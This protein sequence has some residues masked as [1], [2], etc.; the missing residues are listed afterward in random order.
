MRCFV[1]GATGVL[2]RPLVPRLVSAG[3]EVVAVTRS[4][5]KADGLRAAGA[6]PV[7]VDLFEPNAVLAATEGCDAIIHVATNVPPLSKAA[8]RSAWALHNRLRTEA[9]TNL[10]AAAGLN[11]VRCF[12]K[13]SVTFVYPDAGDQWITE[14]MPADETRALLA[15]T[16]EGERIA[17]AFADT[18]ERSSVVLRFG[19]FYG[20]AGNRGTEEMLRLARL[21]SSTLAGRR[22]AYMSSV[23]VDD[24]ASAVVAALAAPTGLHNVVDDEPLTRGDYLAAFSAGFGTPRLHPTPAWLL[25]AVAGK[26]AGALTASQRV[27]NQRMRET[28]GWAPVYP[29][30]REGWQVEGRANRS[31]ERNRA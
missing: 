1:T 22:D 14:S 10:V 3:H 25:R 12:V 30:A 7:E 24:A 31:E 2:G 23:H 13:E 17:L 20:G 26:S 4:A 18:S 9:T 21:R 8:R 28:T 11:G 19:L 16:L 5:D 27:S 15:P 29:S 6:R